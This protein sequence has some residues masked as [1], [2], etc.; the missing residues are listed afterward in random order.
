M[1]EAL[2]DLEWPGGG[3]SI[4]MQRQPQQLVLSS[5]GPN[6]A[7]SIEV[8]VRELSGFHC[9]LEVVRYT[10]RCSSRG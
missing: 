3:V 8:A 7:L 2:E 9:A 1:K 6:G 5:Q 10:Y 4:E